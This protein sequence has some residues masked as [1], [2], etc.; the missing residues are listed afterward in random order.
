MHIILGKRGPQAFI[1]S[2]A[3]SKRP[4][5]GAGVR[6]GVVPKE[7]HEKAGGFP[8]AAQKRDESGRNQCRHHA[9]D[10]R[11]EG[12]SSEAARILFP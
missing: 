4:R 6:I 5:P 11:N 9:G 10:G 12:A 3:P 7:I 8:G 2:A 1:R